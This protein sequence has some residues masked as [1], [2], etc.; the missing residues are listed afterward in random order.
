MT[1]GTQTP[2]DYVV[3]F[4]VVAGS[5][6]H[7][8]SDTGD[9]RAVLFGVEGTGAS[10]E[11]GEVDNDAEVFGALGIIGRPLQPAT[12]KGRSAHAEVVCLR[13]ADGLVPISTRDLRL[14]MQGDG[15]NEGT[16][17][18]I[19]YGGG[20]HSISPVDQNPDN[21][22]IHVVYCPYDY[23]SDGV[24]QKA[25]AVTLDPSSGNES[26][27]IVHA[28]GQSVLMQNDGSIQ[29]QSPDG[30]SYIKIE[31]GAITLSSTQVI[32]NGGMVSV[33]NPVTP[34]AVPLLPGPAS[35]PCPR[36]FV[37]PTA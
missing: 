5:S 17:A 37:S 3:Q 34:P 11:P 13:T 24:A 15:P 21:G 22:S 26:V 12:V 7:S 19:G 32:L 20:F 35:P 1:E 4:G 29:L 31:N 27:T 30:Q 36:L 16:V 33:G 25:H 10:G 18:F 2:L 14:R 8:E 23:D 28:E 9:T 6:L